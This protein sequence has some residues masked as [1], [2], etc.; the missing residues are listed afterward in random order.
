MRQGGKTQRPGSQHTMGY[1]R[2]LAFFLKRRKER[3]TC[4]K[5]KATQIGKQF[6]N[7]HLCAPGRCH[8]ALQPQLLEKCRGCSGPLLGPA[9]G[10]GGRGC[11]RVG[12]GSFY[13]KWCVAWHPS[14]QGTLIA[15]YSVAQSEHE[16]S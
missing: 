14:L 1:N 7:V 9:A 16:D 11:N 13:G 10:W 15:E 4:R 3:E 5:E 8:P 12:W 2:D 6:Q